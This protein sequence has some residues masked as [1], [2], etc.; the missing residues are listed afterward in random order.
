MASQD[1]P[2]TSMRLRFL[3]FLD[4][5][6][7]HYFIMALLLVDFLGNCIVASVTST[8]TFYHA[9]R[10]TRLASAACAIMHLIDSVGRVWSLRR[11]YF[12]NAATA[13]DGLAVVLLLLTLA[14]RFVWADDVKNVVLSQGGWTNK[15]QLFH[16]VLTNQK[17]QYIAALYCLVVAGRICLKPR[18]RTFSKKLHKYANHDK[19]E[20]SLLS[21]RT[22]IHR[23]PGIQAAVVELM[24]MDLAMV[25][26]RQDGNINREELMRFLQK[27][28]QYRPKELSVDAFLAYLRQ[29]DATSSMQSTYGAYEV[30][31]STFRHWASQRFDLALTV[32]VVVLYACIVPG[33][34]YFLQI[35]TDQAFPWY[36]TL[37]PAHDNLWDIYTITN[38][39]KR[40]VYKDEMANENNL[41]PKENNLFIFVPHESLQFGLLGLL[42]LAVPFV[43]CDYAMGYFQSKMIAKATQR[44]QDTLLSVIL[45]QPIQFFNER[46]DGDLNNLFQSDIARVNAMWQAV[47]WNLMQPIVAIAIGFG[48]LLYVQPVVG[49][50]AFSFAAIVVSSGPQGLAAS[51]SD[52]FGKKNAIVS[53]EYQNA[54]ACQKVVRAYAIQSSLLARFGASIQTLGTAQFGKDFW[55]GIVQIYIESAMFIFVAVMTACLSIKVYHGDIT[56]GEFFASVTLIN[57]V[58]TP[59]SVLG[60]FMRVAIG[61]AS[62]LQRLDHVLQME[63]MDNT[64]STP[65][66]N[67]HL[68]Q[69]N[70]AL[71]HVNFHYSTDRQILFDVDVVFKMGEYSCIVG[72]SGCGKSTLLG[73]LMQLHPVS[74]GR[75]MIDGVD[76]KQF[77]SRSVRDQ[78]AVVF[79]QGGVLNGT[80]MDN[81]RYG[82][83]T[84]TDDDCK[85]AAK[86]AECHNFIEQLKDGYD[87]V[88]GQHALV[89]LSGGQLQ[90]I[91]L[92][93]AL[94]REPSVLLLDEAT[95]A[96]DASTEASI[97]ATLERLTRTLNMA[98]VS[99][100]H[101]LNTARNADKIVV[102][103]NGSI[104]ECGKFNE[105]C[106]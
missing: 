30:V 37:D 100:T 78:L 84:A 106:V 42:A 85:R 104:A 88:V 59:V 31:K 79:Q 15:Y 33:L 9:A 69:K 34:A 55:S 4:S 67:L 94:V 46:P 6:P 57:R 83:P 47:F 53:T 96:L 103:S 102:M 8:E 91:C 97:V 60:G 92:A 75:V 21:L 13:I 40:I 101:R 14:A 2:E 50:M 10:T 54:I 25:C 62:S 98:V 49:I 20:I 81:I 26:G 89:N 43:A 16:E 90:R 61:N 27:A 36:I 35:L 64:P 63:P 70:I 52:D 58:S 71:H 93:R 48:F 56:P 23:I 68:M 29:V 32:L 28:M 7:W 74:S 45:S 87:T 24:E 44:M 3:Q 86:S 95:S 66:P 12:R 65:L 17:E 38:V 105:V 51:K 41:N 39:T 99:V 11:S 1:A 77:S 82:Q 19:L 73:C 18:A 80:I 76:L 5:R 72:P 22:A